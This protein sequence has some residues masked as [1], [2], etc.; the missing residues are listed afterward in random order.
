MDGHHKIFIKNQT[1]KTGQSHFLRFIRA[2]ASVVLPPSRGI[3]RVTN[4]TGTVSEMIMHLSS[5]FLVVAFFLLP[6]LEKIFF[7]ILWVDLHL[8]VMRCMNYQ[9]LI[10]HLTWRIIDIQ[11]QK[12]QDIWSELRETISICW[13]G[14]K[15]DILA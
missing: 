3:R 9:H 1:I 13:H 4:N 15:M 7:A 6:N 5:I 10:H 11:E 8:Q 12:N 2:T 14:R